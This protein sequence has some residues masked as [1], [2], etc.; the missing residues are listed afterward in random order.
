[1]IIVKIH[2]HLIDAYLGA[3]AM[4]DIEHLGYV[5]L[6]VSLLFYVVLDFLFEYNLVYFSCLGSGDFY[7]LFDVEI[8]HICHSFDELL[9]AWGIVLPSIVIDCLSCF[10]VLEGLTNAKDIPF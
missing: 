4:N 3:L 1:M 7:W 5:S 10:L 2:S 8:E 9:N 6:V